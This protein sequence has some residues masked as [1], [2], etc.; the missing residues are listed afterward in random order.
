M[1]KLIDTD[2]IN[3]IRKT[4]LMLLEICL[5]KSFFNLQFHVSVSIKKK[6]KYNSTFYTLLICHLLSKTHLQVF[7]K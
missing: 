7:A 2:K 5:S 3:K 1:F 6:V 4:N